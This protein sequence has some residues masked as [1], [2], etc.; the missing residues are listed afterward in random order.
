MVRIQC[1]KVAFVMQWFSARRIGINISG[2]VSPYIPIK[3]S[4]QKKFNLINLFTNEAK[5]NGFYCILLSINMLSKLC[6]L[7]AVADRDCGI[8][9]GLEELSFLSNCNDDAHL[10]SCLLLKERFT[11]KDLILA[12]AGLF[13]IMEAQIEKILVCPRQRHSLRKFWQ[14]PR[15]CQ[16]PDHTRKSTSNAGRH[17]IGLKLAREI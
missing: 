17:V 16:Y 12:R 4:H 9:R 1:T 14:S 11:E 3:F 10:A 8:S 15:S 2:K 7:N 13:S 6:S 5:I